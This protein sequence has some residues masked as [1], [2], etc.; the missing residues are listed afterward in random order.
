MMVPSVPAAG[1]L[2]VL[3]LVAVADVVLTGSCCPQADSVAV[4][5]AAAPNAPANLKRS[6]RGTGVGFVIEAP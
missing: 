6:Q 4:K 5:A 3:P 2:P 1:A